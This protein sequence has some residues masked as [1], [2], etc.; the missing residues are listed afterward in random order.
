MHN[1]QYLRRK[2]D[3]KFYHQIKAF[4]YEAKREA[5]DLA[6]RLKERGTYKSV[7]VISGA[8]TSKYFG[9]IWIVY[10]R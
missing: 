8:P 4:P 2:I 5:Q 10:G 3:G 1:A 9:K 6:R 7:R